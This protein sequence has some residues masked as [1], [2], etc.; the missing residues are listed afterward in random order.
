MTFIL[1]MLVFTLAVV[2]MCLGVMLGGRRIKG[3]CGGLNTIPGIESD[4]GGACHADRDRAE[5]K[6]HRRSKSCANRSREACGRHA[7]AD[8][9]SARSGAL[10]KEPSWPYPLP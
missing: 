4:C 8:S 2:L 1:S 9:E 5:H 6:C 3:S 7:E 10:P